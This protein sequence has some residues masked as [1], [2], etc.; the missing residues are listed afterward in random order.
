MTA[1]PPTYQPHYIKP[2]SLGTETRPT[3][4][5]KTASIGSHAEAKDWGLL[6][7]VQD[8]VNRT[9]TRWIFGS[10]LTEVR[11]TAACEAQNCGKV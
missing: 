7:N 3:M 4:G 1:N 6:M 11:L 5:R 8:Q 2:R 9:L 10:R